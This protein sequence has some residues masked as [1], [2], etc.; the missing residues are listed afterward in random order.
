M[1][2]REMAEGT[3]ISKERK[4]MAELLDQ[5]QKERGVNISEV[6]SSQWNELVRDAQKILQAEKR[7]I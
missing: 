6:D 2:E 5:L 3:K 1:D 7:Q 4:R